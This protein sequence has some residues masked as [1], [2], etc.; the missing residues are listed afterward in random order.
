[1]SA[2]CQK[3]KVS[4]EGQQR[5][6]LLAAQ[7]GQ[8]VAGAEAGRQAGRQVAQHGIAGGVA[9]GVVDGL[10]VV[11]IDQHHRQRLAAAGAALQLAPGQLEEGAGWP[12]R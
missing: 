7:A 1:M 6:E 9:M 5:H 11:G 4:K 10:E 2:S 3:G 8:H 12:A